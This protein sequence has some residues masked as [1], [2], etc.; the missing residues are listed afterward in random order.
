[1]I[2]KK[3]LLLITIVT[4]LI[5]CNKNDKNIKVEDTKIQKE[6]IAYD[7]A[8]EVLYSLPSPIETAMIIE[9]VNTKFNDEY[10]LPLE[11]INYYET[12]YSKATILGV[13]SADLSYIS[14]F[15]QQ[16]LAVKYLSNCKKIA[17]SLGILEVISDSVIEDMSRSIKRKEEVLEIITNEY[18]KINSYLEDNNRQQ[19]AALMVY[20]GWIEGLYI[21]TKLVNN[22]VTKNPDL[23]Q[24]I[25]DQKLSLEDLIN[26]MNIFK[27]N[28]TI[29]IY[30][31]Y[32][33]ELNEIY[34]NIKTPLTQSDF[35]IIQTKVSNIRTN[36][37][38]N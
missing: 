23:V 12:S 3:I 32:L 34:K 36:I 25:Y 13:Y 4:I 37:V 2:S 22:D 35:D 1:M 10:L 11:Y 7:K 29:K 6:N 17:E 19:L 28:E 5:S 38:K 33:L 21:S 31:Q 20:G 15:D 14:M 8:K 18:M 27:N 26:L 30:T 24:T 9:N 16:Q